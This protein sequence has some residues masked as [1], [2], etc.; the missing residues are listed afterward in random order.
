MSWLSKLGGT[1]IGPELLVRPELVHTVSLGYQ[2]R[3]GEVFSCSGGGE[4]RIVPC[5]FTGDA[6]D[7]P[8]NV[9]S[10]APGSEYH[11]AVMIRNTYRIVDPNSITGQG[12]EDPAKWRTSGSITVSLRCYGSDA[13]ESVDMLR[14]ECRGIDSGTNIFTETSFSFSASHAS[15]FT[16]DT[17]QTGVVVITSTSDV[18][19][20]DN[21]GYMIVGTLTA[22]TAS[23]FPSLT[24]STD[25]V[26]VSAFTTHNS[27][28]YKVVFPQT[29]VNS[30]IVIP[31]RFSL[32]LEGTMIESDP[33]LHLAHGGRAD[34]RGRNNALYN[35]FSAPGLSVNLKTEE[36]TARAE[37]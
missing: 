21:S 2:E 33:H 19:Y 20:P 36:A 16:A 3:I 12:S 15:S 23:S 13:D 27:E 25:T 32:D 8:S 10:I 6:C 31:N 34:F 4:L 28:S 11:F 30:G 1:G 5:V 7:T 22:R 9:V 26:E 24:R 37:Q 29:C 18:D 17:S 14:K 35:F